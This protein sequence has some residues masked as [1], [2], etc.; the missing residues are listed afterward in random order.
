MTHNIIVGLSCP[1]SVSG[2]RETCSLSEGV[3]LVPVV[4][5]FLGV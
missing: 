3:S 4:D 5:D 1:S 2:D